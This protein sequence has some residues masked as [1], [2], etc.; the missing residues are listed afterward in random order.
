M[1]A[2]P[3]SKDSRCLLAVRSTDLF[4]QS[5]STTTNDQSKRVRTEGIHSERVSRACNRV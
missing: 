1:Y 4:H 5:N 3:G 2:V